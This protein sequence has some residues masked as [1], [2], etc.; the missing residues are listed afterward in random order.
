MNIIAQNL[1]DF[2]KPSCLSSGNN[3]RFNI[4]ANDRVL[5]KYTPAQNMWLIAT[6]LKAG[7]D[8]ITVEI[9]SGDQDVRL[10][11]PHTKVSAIL[12]GD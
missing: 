10:N 11:I 8:E 9:Q 7:A 5:L 3:I 6:V 1:A 4:Q 12:I 2:E